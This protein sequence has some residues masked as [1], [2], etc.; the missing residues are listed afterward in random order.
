MV[1]RLQRGPEAGKGR[2]NHMAH[3]SQKT[4]EQSG[5][6]PNSIRELEPSTTRLSAQIERGAFAQ[7]IR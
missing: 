7:P 6:E 2:N 4:Q 3:H 1:L 5:N